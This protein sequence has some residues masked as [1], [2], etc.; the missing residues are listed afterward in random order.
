ML[1]N[2]GR[3]FNEV[4]EIFYFY[5]IFFKS[6]TASEVQSRFKMPQHI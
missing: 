5:F 1:M 4:K 6:R 2:A 3:V